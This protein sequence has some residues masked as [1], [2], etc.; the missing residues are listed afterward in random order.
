MSAE[1][2]SII[3]PSGLLRRSD[4]WCMQSTCILLSAV[5][6][7]NRYPCYRLRCLQNPAPVTQVTPTEPSQSTKVPSKALNLLHVLCFNQ[8]VA[9]TSQ[10]RPDIGPALGAAGKIPTGLSPTT[11]LFLVLT[12]LSSINPISQTF[13]A[14]VIQIWKPLRNNYTTGFQ[15]RQVIVTSARRVSPPTV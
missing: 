6:L 13:C 14:R 9:R 8:P 7:L 10:D 15:A 11:A 5:H 12:F 4:E 3:S 2:N 1:D